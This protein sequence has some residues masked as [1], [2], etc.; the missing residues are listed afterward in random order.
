MV[1][2]KYL[3]SGLGIIGSAHLI[4]AILGAL[5]WV[6]IASFLEV[7]SFGKISFDM[8]IP[9]IL[10]AVG[11]LG[12]NTTIIVYTPK[13]K[14]EIKQP[15]NIL[16]LV[17]TTVIALPLFSISWTLPLLLIASNFFYMSLASFLG[18]KSYKKYAILIIGSRVAQLFLSLIFYLWLGSDGILVGYALAFLIFSHKFLLSLKIKKL[19]LS[20]LRPYFSF[21]LN[22]FASHISSMLYAW[23]DKVVIAILFGYSFLGLY[24]LAFQ[25]VA[26]VS[27]IPSIL[28]TYLLPEEA[29]GTNTKKI[30]YLGYI[31]SAIITPLAFFTIPLILETFFPNYES[32][33]DAIKIMVLSLFPS[34]AVAI[35]HTQFLGREDSRTPL[36]GIL[37]FIIV[38]MSSIFTLGFSYGLNGI[39]IGFVI[40]HSSQGLYLWLKNKS[41]K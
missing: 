41:Q 35:L 31:S 23:L 32:A 3:F 11:L 1:F 17:A 8:S 10:G 33:I 25:F 39:A 26:F 4:Q 19:K 5:F 13:G 38:I 18:D 30:R 40:S 6:I 9:Y 24:T 16:V 20:I 12:L 34:T 37:I 21:T 27:F 7:E 2:R 36:I 14:K 29:S 15:A 28:G 22:N